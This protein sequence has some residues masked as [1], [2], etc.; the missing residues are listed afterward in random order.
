MFHD[1]LVDPGEAGFPAGASIPSALAR[2]AIFDVEHQHG[3]GSGQADSGEDRARPRDRVDQSLLHDSKH[4]NFKIAVEP[5][6][7]L[8][9][10]ELDASTVRLDEA[11]DI[12][13]EGNAQPHVV[14]RGR[15]EQVGEFPDLAQQVVGDGAAAGDGFRQTR[16][17]RGLLLMEDAEVNGESGQKLSRIFVQFDGDAALLLIAG[18]QQAAR[19]A[20]QFLF[21]G[22]VLA[23]LLNQFLIL[24]LHLAHVRLGSPTLRDLGF[25]DLLC[26]LQECDRA[27]VVVFNRR[28]RK[29]LR[30]NDGVVLAT[31]SREQAGV[32]L[33]IETRDGTA[34][35]QVKRVLRRKLVPQL[36]EPESPRAVSALPQEADHLP[37]D[38]D[39]GVLVE[40]GARRAGNHVADAFAEQEFIRAAIQQEPVE[41]FS[42]VE[43]DVAPLADGGSQVRSITTQL[44]GQ[45]DTMG[46]GGYNDG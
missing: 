44:V 16:I 30:R 6:E 43:G 33:A 40:G 41:G 22:L 10:F 18:R 8:G 13:P 21:D 3:G 37:I 28:L 31:N 39:R 15:M 36:L 38:R 45:A 17:Q 35:E 20:T 7:T 9:D 34:A 5:S 25:Q 23:K 19:E 12:I 4:G 29:T 46:S 42:G 1:A 11:V 26:L 27:R 2:L 14:Q 24:A 32:S